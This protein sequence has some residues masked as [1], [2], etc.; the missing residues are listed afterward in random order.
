MRRLLLLRHAKSDW[1]K[2]GQPDR[3][4][5]LNARGRAAAPL[6]GAF[7]E[8]HGLAPDTAYVS[9]AERARETWA[10]LAANLRKIPKVV[11]EDRLYQATPETI[12]DVVRATPR[13]AQTVL[14]LGHNPGLQ[15]L[16]IDL[17]G[18]GDLELRARLIEKFPTAAVAVITF[19]SE[20]WAGIRSQSGRL[21]RFV[22]PSALV[23][24][25]E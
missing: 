21:E 11:F 18:S 22:S 14:V 17:C 24:E 9:T 6:M 15:R 4:R 20:D 13:G 3:M 25:P 2:P 19:A 23:A 16:A 12:L 5:A 10:L 7:L 8:R 1:S